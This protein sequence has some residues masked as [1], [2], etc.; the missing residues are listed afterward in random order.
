M[1]LLEYAA[2]WTIQSTMR[3]HQ[4]K[5]AVQQIPGAIIEVVAQ[6]K[7]EVS[8]SWQIVWQAGSIHFGV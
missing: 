1:S 3:V 6:V 4:T 2:Q 8:K 5:E 7:A